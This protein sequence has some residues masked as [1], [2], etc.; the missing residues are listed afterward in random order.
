M[1]AGRNKKHQGGRVATRWLL[2]VP[3]KKGWANTAD[4]LLDVLLLITIRTIALVHLL[5]IP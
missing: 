2:I 3:I 5:A 4:P 1:T